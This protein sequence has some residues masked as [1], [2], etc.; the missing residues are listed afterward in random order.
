LPS[1]PT[2]EPGDWLDHAALG[3]S[4]LCLV[5]CLALPLIIAALPALSHLLSIPESIHVWILLFALPTAGLAFVTGRARHGASYPLV[6]G[7]LGLMALATG[8]AFGNTP[9]ETPVTVT[10]SL[11]LAAAH[12]ANWRLRHAHGHA[13]CG[14]DCTSAHPHPG[15]KDVSGARCPDPQI[16]VRQRSAGRPV[17]DVR[18]NPLAADRIDQPAYR[19]IAKASPA[20]GPERIEH[21]QEVPPTPGQYILI[22][23]RPLAI[24]SPVEQSRIGQG[25]QSPR[26]DVRRD[27][28]ALL[29]LVKAGAPGAGVAQHQH[30]PGIADA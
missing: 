29:E 30:A 11:L 25:S 26:Q 10:G 13:D 7:V 15:R 23:G 14:H 20:P 16:D 27:A 3:A 18:F 6:I 12:I 19:P 4:A 5:H 24:A 1:K 21:R 9:I 8:V 28:Q 22:P 17:H 2:V